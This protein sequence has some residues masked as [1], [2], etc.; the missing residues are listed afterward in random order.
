MIE[1]SDAV[2]IMQGPHAELQRAA[3]RLADHGID[4]AIMCPDA[5]RGSS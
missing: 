3:Q 4:A 5:N 1:E 2:V